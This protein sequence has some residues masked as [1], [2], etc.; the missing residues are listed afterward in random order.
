MFIIQRLLMN[1][2]RFAMREY[3]FSSRR[4]LIL[5]LKQELCSFAN[6]IAHSED[7]FITILLPFRSAFVFLKTITYGL[8][9]QQTLKR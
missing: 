2:M 4:S 1:R 5:L 7:D 9:C 3:F 6:H 8:D